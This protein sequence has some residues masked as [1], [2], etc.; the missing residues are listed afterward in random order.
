MAAVARIAPTPIM[1]LFLD[2]LNEKGRV[3]KEPVIDFETTRREHVDESVYAGERQFVL[4]D[5]D[6][7]KESDRFLCA[8]YERFLS[9]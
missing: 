5:D 1:S 7:R 8:D 3:G 9:Q 2:G 4:L 6:V